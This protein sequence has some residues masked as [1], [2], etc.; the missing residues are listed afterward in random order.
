MASGLPAVLGNGCGGEGLTLPRQHRTTGGGQPGK[1]GGPAHC[2]GLAPVN[3][4]CQGHIHQVQIPGIGQR[5]PLALQMTVLL[6][7]PM[8]AAKQ[9]RLHRLLNPPVGQGLQHHLRTNPGG[10]PQGNGNGP[11]LI[12]GQGF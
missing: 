10:I 12:H 8:A 4:L 2:R 1:T 9:H 5:M 11:R 6:Q 7:E 3:R